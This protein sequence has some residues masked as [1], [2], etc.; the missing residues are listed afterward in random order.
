MT[1]SIVILQKEN[2]SFQLATEY[3][4]ILSIYFALNTGKEEIQL[5]F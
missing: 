3:K 5:V 2:N 4:L 1:D